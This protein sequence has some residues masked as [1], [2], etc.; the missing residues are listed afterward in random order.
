MAALEPHSPAVELHA[1]ATPVDRNPAAVYLARLAPSGRRTQQGALNRIVE[2]FTDD[3]DALSFP[4]HLLRYE[5]AQAVRRRLADRYAPATVDKALSALRSVLREAWRLGLMDGETYQR[6]ADVRNLTAT[7]L[8]AGRALEPGELRALFAVC[9]A[10]GR[11]QGAR[12]AA[13]FALMY[14]AGL[15]R[16]EIVALE[17]DDYTPDTGA[18]AVRNA[19]GRNDRLVY[20]TNGARDALEAWLEARGPDPGPLFVPVNKAGNV[21]VRRMT[22]QAVLYRCRVRAKQAGVGQFSPHDLRR[23]FVGDLLE[24]G[25]DLA[26]VQRL[27]G[28]A[29]PSTT[30]RYDRRPEHAKRRAAE[31]LHVPYWR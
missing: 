23:T 11:P 6:A 18:L 3:L 14:G 1:A 19:K 29:Q 9:A 17:V 31:L 4:W 22:A 8:P 2:L 28:H 27:A 15:R 26:M 5:H 16:S 13:L 10:D 12:D 20:A 30:A 7:R 25:A 21:R 24:A